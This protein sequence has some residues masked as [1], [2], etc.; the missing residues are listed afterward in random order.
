MLTSQQIKLIHIARRAGW[1]DDGAY[2][3]LLWNVAQRVPVWELDHVG[4]RT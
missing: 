1:A 2:R 3:V 4:T